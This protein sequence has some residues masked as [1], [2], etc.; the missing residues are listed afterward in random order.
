MTDEKEIR[1]L[2][3]KAEALGARVIR[4]RDEEA[5]RQEGRDL[6]E[7]LTIHIAKGIGPFPMSPISGA[8]R[9][10]EFISH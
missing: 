5:F 9:L 7:T 10:R 2:I 1:A 6:T 4:T 8:E 3:Q